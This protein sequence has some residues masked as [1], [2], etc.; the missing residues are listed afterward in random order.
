MART[1]VDISQL[2]LTSRKLGPH[3]EVDVLA[4]KSIIA[5]HEQ[6]MKK[7]DSEIEVLLHDVRKLQLDKHRHQKQIDLCKG[8]ITLATRIPFEVL[9]SVFERCC[10]EGYTR[11]PLAVSRVCSYWL[12]AASLPSVWSHLYI[13]TDTNNAIE[14]TRLWLEKVRGGRLYITIDVGGDVAPLPRIM[15]LLLAKSSQWRALAITASQ[16]VHANHLLELCNVSTPEL[17]TVRISASGESAPGDTSLAVIRRS[18]EEAPL[19]RSIQLSFDNTP[20][21]GLLPN[22]ITSLSLTFP[23]VSTQP[24]PVSDIVSV[25][26]GLPD[27]SSLYLAFPHRRSRPIELDNNTE[28]VAIL[29]R[30][31]T[32]TLVGPHDFNSI[33]THLLTPRAT[34]LHLRFSLE[35]YGY[36]HEPTGSW[37]LQYVE[38]SHP[39]LEVLDFRDLDI[40]PEHFSTCLSALPR[41]KQLCIHESEVPDSVFKLLSASTGI[42]PALTHLD[43]RWCGQVTGQAL[44]ELVESRLGAPSSVSRIIQVTVIHCAFVQEDDIIELARRTM[45]RLLMQDTGDY[46]RP[47]GCCQNERYRRRM[48]NRQLHAKVHPG[49][50]S[51]GRLVV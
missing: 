39:P 22:W 12:K 40:L 49:G 34:E 46:C 43:L 16:L 3:S 45:C 1:E 8:L 4:V 10:R 50:Q 25:L 5:R 29:E 26:E 38:Q 35:S 24:L 17:R 18:I 9:A 31:E 7:L 41:L 47:I 32:I 37:L 23:A 13:K 11:T 19:L 51:I 48:R 42:C 44:V 20:A 28:H 14:R 15:D 21:V 27:L 36:P 30:L 33:L 2:T 6:D